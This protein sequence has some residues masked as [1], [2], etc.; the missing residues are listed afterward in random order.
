M[1][2]FEWDVISKIVLMLI[3]V[4]V[5]PLLV[6]AI[7]QFT[8][9]L[10]MIQQRDDWEFIQQSVWTAVHTAEQLGL[11][12]DIAMYGEEKLKVATAM[13]NEMLLQRGIKINAGEHVDLIRGMIEAALR[14]AD[15]PNVGHVAV[16][17]Q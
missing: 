15:F 7:R 3:E 8:R 6:I 13:V 16:D 11:G 14:E 2:D 5:P 17:C 4:I 10:N 1:S 9:W 12:A